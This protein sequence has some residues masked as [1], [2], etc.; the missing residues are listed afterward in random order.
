MSDHYYSKK[1]QSKS[2]PKTQDYQ[3]LGRTYRLTTDTGVFSKNQID[4]GTRLL[5]ESFKSPSIN[6]KLLDLG[7]GYGPLGVAIADHFPERKIVL[8]DINERAISLAQK[9]IDQNNIKNAEVI[10]SD[11]FLQ[12]RNYQFAAILTNP[13]IRAG[14]KVVYQMFEDSKDALY[15]GGELWIVIQKKQGAPSAKNKLEELFQSV[16]IVTRKKG[17]YIIRAIKG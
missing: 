2:N 11:G 4:Y 8:V 12:I 6:G 9:N 3:L 7:C 10:L 15:K 17:Y 13:P 1:P 16:D 14:K 5:I